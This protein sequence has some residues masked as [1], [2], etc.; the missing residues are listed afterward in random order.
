MSRFRRDSAAVRDLGALGGRAAGF[1]DPYHQALAPALVTLGGY[2]T[3]Q[4]SFHDW[5]HRRVR[6]YRRSCM[7]R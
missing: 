3:I 2:L 1:H 7:G 4:G 5:Y 6:R